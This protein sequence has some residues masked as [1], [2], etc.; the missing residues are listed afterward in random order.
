MKLQVEVKTLSGETVSLD[1]TVSPGDTVQ[2]IKERVALAEPNPFPDSTLRHNKEKL[3]D[4]KT[5]S[6]CGLQ[7]GGLVAFTVEASEGAL[8]DQFKEMLRPGAPT[9]IEELSLMYSL[10][11]GAS[12]SEALQALGKDRTIKDFFEGCGK[13]FSVEG[14]QVK[15]LAVPAEVKPNVAIQLLTL[16]VLVSLELPSYTK[17]VDTIDLQVKGDETVA[18]LK[19]RVAATAA[20][21]LANTRLLSG[22]KVLDDASCMA[23]HGFTSDVKLSFVASASQGELV[24]QLV[25]VLQ[26]QGP[27]SAVGLDNAYCCR[28][29]GS[30]TQAVQLLG[31]GERLRGFLERQPE[32]KVEKGCIMLSQDSPRKSLGQDGNDKHLALHAK[33]CIAAFNEQVSHAMDHLASTLSGETFLNIQ[34]IVKGGAVAKGIAIPGAVD[35]QVVVFM[36]GLPP[37]G[38]E[39][40][41]PGLARSLAGVMAEQFNGEGGITQVRAVGSTVQVDTDSPLGT[42]QVFLSP[43]YGSYAETLEALSMQG[44]Q[45]R[46]LGAPALTSQYVRFVERQPEGVKATMR[47]MQW[48]REQKQWSSDKT[49][50]S[51]HLLELVVAHTVKERAP[52]NLSK[53]I[54]EVLAVLSRVD[55]VNITWPS[56]VCT[57]REGDIW[58]PLLKQ[59]PL[60]MDPTNPFMNVADPDQ[61]LPSEVMRYAKSGSLFI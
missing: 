7:D 52:P 28:Y 14:G 2:S 9:S 11:H 29:G 45:V 18:T 32:F 8:I 31:W 41:L 36:D 49:R 15:R 33:L 6:Q 21:P 51:N 40:Y 50:P 19:K 48:W 54:E 17:E 13:H 35:A 58:K 59:Q 44:P 53:A 39:T 61:F 12:A 30:A 60:V 57:Y 34:R 55:Q 4:S 24:Q 43:T 22:S 1:L 27:Q 25:A 5:L 16:T 20:V 47:L 23:Y 38:Q 46:Y 37:T 10:K 42:V 26:E 3:L 56:S